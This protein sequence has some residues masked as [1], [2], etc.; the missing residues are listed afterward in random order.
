[1]SDVS[2]LSDL[3]KERIASAKLVQIHGWIYS[4]RTQGAGSLVFLHINDG[5]SVAP[6]RCL[7]EHHSENS[8]AST[9]K[10]DLLYDD[11]A[12]DIKY[13]YKTPKGLEMIDTTEYKKLAFGGRSCSVRG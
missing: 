1:M 10:G 13:G 4:T 2:K 8:A 3:S 11:C 9:T 6:I 12:S 5:S 7:A